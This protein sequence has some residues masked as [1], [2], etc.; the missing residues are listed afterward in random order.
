MESSTTRCRYCE[1]RVWNYWWSLA[2]PGEYRVW[3]YWW[4]L[5]Q[6]G[7]Y[8]VWNYWWSLAQPG[9]YRVWNYWWSLAQP[10][11][12]TVNIE[13][14]ITLRSVSSSESFYELPH[15]DIMG[16]PW[17]LSQPV[18]LYW[19]RTNLYGAGK[20]ERASTPRPPVEKSCALATAPPWW[21]LSS[22]KYVDLDRRV[23]VCLCD[24]F[25][26]APWHKGYWIISIEVRSLDWL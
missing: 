18:T 11:A 21:S 3:N 9:E 13:S 23:E 4:S 14:G 24:S 16:R 7:E 26:R 20:P 25:D 17:L 5:A 15:R 6:P 22:H 2:Q 1:Y 8:R 12:G 19:H 10:G